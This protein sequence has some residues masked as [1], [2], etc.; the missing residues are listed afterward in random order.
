MIPVMA[1]LGTVV[2][3]LILLDRIVGLFLGGAWVSQHTCSSCRHSYMVLPSLDA[4]DRGLT[5][6]FVPPTGH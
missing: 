2:E 4:G 6:D 3:V 1:K 5:C